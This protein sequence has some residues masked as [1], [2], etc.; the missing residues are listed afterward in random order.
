MKEVSS[1]A[2]AAVARTKSLL[3][4]SLILRASLEETVRHSGY[5][6]R[7]SPRLLHGG[8]SDS[9]PAGVII[10]RL[11][12]IDGR[13][14]VLTTG[15]RIVLS[16][17]ADIPDCPVGTS[18]KIVLVEHDGVVVGKSVDLLRRVF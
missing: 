8:S 13:S 18:L 17:E 4:E 11:E 10:G 1:R 2:S 7:H 6:A 3:R 5:L 16:P 12:C 15:T 14:L 9:T